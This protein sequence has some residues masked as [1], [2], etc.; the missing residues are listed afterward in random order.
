M[1]FMHP[2]ID[3]RHLIQRARN[4]KT[5]STLAS[6][7][8]RHR[9]NQGYLAPSPDEDSGL[10]I[11][12]I[13]G[14]TYKHI[15]IKK[16]KK[17]LSEKTPEEIL[18]GLHISTW[19]SSDGS[20]IL[21]KY[22]A[23]KQKGYWARNG[24]DE[25]D[26]IK[27]VTTILGVLNLRNSALKSTQK[28]KTVQDGIVIGKESKIEDLS[29]LEKVYGLILI[30]AKNTQEAKEILEKLNFHPRVFKGK[31]ISIPSPQEMNKEYK[32]KRRKYY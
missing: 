21:S 18:N 7:E 5:L 22:E 19:I 31:I 17:K 15:D 10:L 12:K 20:K 8:N 1:S 26:L 6:E 4:S 29:S 27:D 14:N 28:I 9:T 30:E 3:A 13:D 25:N 24:I 16:E 2:D 11:N 32:P 23:P